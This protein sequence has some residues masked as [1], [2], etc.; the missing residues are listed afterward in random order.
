[1]SYLAWLL[2]MALCGWIAGRIVGRNG[3]GNVADFLLGITG[4]LAVRFCF[5]VLRV[6]VPGTDA[7]VFSV[8]GA[9]ALPALVRF[10]IRQGDRQ[11]S[12]LASQTPPAVKGRVIPMPRITTRKGG[13]ACDRETTAERVKGQSTGNGSSDSKK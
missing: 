3:R 8:C 5:D 7:L 2:L 9:A 6:T 4:G 11:G 1:M 10:L 12:V 13:H